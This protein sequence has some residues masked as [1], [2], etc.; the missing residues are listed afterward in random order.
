MYKI[1]TMSLLQPVT[2]AAEELKKY[3]SMMVPEC[4][5]IDITYDPNATDGFRLGLL[6]DFNL[7]CEAPDATQDDVVHVETT[8]EGG[9]LAGSNP[10][11]VLFAVYRFLK[12]NGCR[13]L[14]PGN[15]GEYIPR[16]PIEPVQ[17]HKMADHR[18]RGHTTEGAPS[19]DHVLSYIDY[20]AKQEMNAYGLFGL[21]PY[22]N[23]FYLHGHNEKNRPPEPIDY[24]LVE[25]WTKLCE[26]EITKRG[27]QVWEGG[28]EF[29][30]KAVGLDPA[31]RSLYKKKKKT[32]PEEV[33]PRLA[34][35][36]GKRGLR[37]NDPQYTNFCMSQPALR[38][39]FAEVVVEEMEK[40]GQMDQFMVA[41]ADTNNNHCE[42]EECQK[43]TP[44]DY[45][46]MC[47]NEMD[48]L[49]TEKG[50]DAKIQFGAYVDTMFA[51]EKIRFN[52][53]DRFV[54]L[55]CPISRDYTKSLTPDSVIPE[56]GKYVRNNWEMPDSTEGGYALFKQWLDVF[57]GTSIAYEYHYWVHQYRDPGMMSM[58]RRIYE[59]AYSWKQ[60][61]MNGAIQDGSNRSFFPNGFIDH[62]Y[63]ATLWNRDLDFEAEAE[64]Y[65]R[66]C[67]GDDWKQ[68]RYYL[69]RMSAA[70]DHGYMCGHRSA[71]PDKG[72]HY[73]PSRISALQSVHELAAEIR[74]LVKDHMAMPTRPQTVCWR[75]LLWHAKWCEGLAD[76]MIQK[77]QG[78]TQYAL[79]KLRV[80]YDEIGAGEFDY[81]RYFDFGLASI[82]LYNIVNQRPKVEF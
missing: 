37:K 41:L 70:F 33:I 59:D 16:K 8:V 74:A 15:D 23:R 53:P 22:H 18:Y 11:S 50:I 81:E 13:F 44:S 40:N 63:G 31:D 43:L 17:Y 28:H 80:F 10:R 51:P 72:E 5:K 60:T 24:S 61:G 47:L 54:L 7:P 71:D 25:Q 65:F 57:P 69:D 45:Y 12:E 79:E 66:Y 29:V 19:L 73:D 35:M 3:L 4:G 32:V 76:V 78:H 62:I 9:V 58:A 27:M 2:F 39:R 75:L 6:E 42:C 49:L 82:S 21:H 56:P 1:Y 55:Y 38:R 36:N 26:A 64:D 48:A 30:I 46:V 68:V 52:N 77:C 67:Y 14:F 34:M 20:Q